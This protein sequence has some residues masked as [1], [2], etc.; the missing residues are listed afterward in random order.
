[1]PAHKSG[2]GALAQDGWKIDTDTRHYLLLAS[3]AWIPTEDDMMANSHTSVPCMCQEEAH[4][5]WRMAREKHC[6]SD[7]ACPMRH[8]RGPHCSTIR[9]CLWASAGAAPGLCCGLCHGYAA[10]RRQC[11]QVHGRSEKRQ[12]HVGHRRWRCPSQI[13]R[14]AA[15][16][17]HFLPREAWLRRRDSNEC[18]R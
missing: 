7:L 17:Q 10:A 16:N 5:P 6:A 1:M 11:C 9:C 15:D 2:W 4:S 13:V 3:G 12:G 8:H 18:A 14:S